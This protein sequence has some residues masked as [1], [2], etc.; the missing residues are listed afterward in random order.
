MVPEIGQVSTRDPVTR[1]YISG[2]ALTRYSA[3]PRLTST[4]YGAGFRSRSRL[5]T[6]E[7]A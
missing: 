6:T 5:K 3:S 4:P 7:G 1:T 2:D